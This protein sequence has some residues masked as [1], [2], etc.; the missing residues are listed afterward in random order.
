VDLSQG[1]VTQPVTVTNPNPGP[2]PVTS[3]TVTGDPSFTPV[4]DNCSNTAIP[5]NG[6]CIVTVQFAPTAPGS[7]SADLAIAT[8]KTK[9]K[10]SSGLLTGTGIWRLYLTAAGPGSITDSQGNTCGPP[11]SGKV[12][13]TIPVTTSQVTLTGAPDCPGYT[14]GCY[15][16]SWAFA[17]G[18]TDPTCTITIAADTNVEATFQYAIG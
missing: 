8:T 2:L 6:S 15:F 1:P 12:T 11:L 17:C 13:C 7:Y 10:Q 4:S 16:S 9:T 14:Y 18:G 3:T 5:A